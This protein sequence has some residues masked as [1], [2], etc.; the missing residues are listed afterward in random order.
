MVY[1]MSHIPECGAANYFPIARN[2]ILSDIM[3]NISVHIHENKPFSGH[4]DY[5]E[6]LKL[7]ELGNQLSGS[8][9]TFENIRNF[10]Y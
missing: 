10:R 6:D 8:V 5:F 4:W 2:H 3:I 9:P 7:N 1:L